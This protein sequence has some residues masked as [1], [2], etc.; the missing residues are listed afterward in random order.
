MPAATSPR[1]LFDEYLTLEYLYLGDL[2][3]ALDEPPDES[4]R[5][6]LLAV[7]ESLFDAMQAKPGLTRSLADASAALGPAIAELIREQEEQLTALAEVRNR[8][9]ERPSGDKH[10]S[11]W[12]KSLADWMERIARHNERIR[13]DLRPLLTPEPSSDSRP[14]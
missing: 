1:R 8:V 14:G 10:S 11:A 6:W 7:V 2:R 13:R 9:L 12:R 5:K 3:A 4:G